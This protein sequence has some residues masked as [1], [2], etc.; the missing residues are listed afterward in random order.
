MTRECR[1]I[2]ISNTREA[3]Y[4]YY[5]HSPEN[6]IILDLSALK[7]A[8]G[9]FVDRSWE[10]KN[11]F[12]KWS[13]LNLG[14]L[15]EAPTYRDYLFQYGGRFT[16]FVVLPIPSGTLRDDLPQVS[17]GLPLDALIAAGRLIVADVAGADDGGFYHGRLSPGYSRTASENT[18]QAGFDWTWRRREFLDNSYLDQLNASPVL[19]ENAN[20][21]FDFCARRFQTLMRKWKREASHFQGSLEFGHVPPQRG[22]QF[23]SYSR[24]NRDRV[25]RICEHLQSL[26]HEIWIDVAS[27]PYGE[28][29]IERLYTGLENCGGVI[30]M[31][32]QEHSLSD[33]CLRE[34]NFAINRTKKLTP[35]WLTTPALYRKM[36]L[37]LSIYNAIIAAG[38]SDSDIAN[39]ISESLR[40]AG[41]DR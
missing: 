41:D 20:R 34:I 21:F 36:E 32:S 28:D 38:R 3:I 9:E 16:P 31:C 23:I 1:R 29:F 8:G 2:S 15:I 22:Y 10:L 7:N 33:W 18:I 25:F 37:L 27:I 14:R 11:L 6:P 26:G 24:Q 4:F 5:Y 39:V 12:D 30:A 13:R 40:S 19:A 17:G 35:V